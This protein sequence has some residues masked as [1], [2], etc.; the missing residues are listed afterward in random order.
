MEQKATD[1]LKKISL[2]D[3]ESLL[4][5]K[6]PKVFDKILLL[7]NSLIRDNF[8]Q[9]N[10]RARNATRSLHKL[11]VPLHS[12]I[13]SLIKNLLS[14]RD[15]KI[16]I[17]IDSLNKI[18]SI[19]GCEKTNLYRNE[20]KNAY[21]F[22]LEE[23]AGSI[24]DNQ[25]PYYLPNDSHIDDCHTCNGEKYIACNN[26]D[27][28][29]RHEWT[30]PNC[31]GDGKV[32]CA[33]CSGH[34][35]I[36]CNDC[37]G[38]GEK[39]C[40]NLIWG[41]NGS[42]KV[43]DDKTRKNKTCTKCKG[44][45][46]IKCKTCK[47]KGE[48]AC[49]RCSSKGVVVCSKCSGKKTI[50]CKVCYGDQKRY[51]LVDCPTCLTNG[52]LISFYYVTTD[53]NVLEDKNL[54]RYETGVLIKDSKFKEILYD[55]LPLKTFFAQNNKGKQ[56]T[57]DKYSRAFCK[58]MRK[59]FDLEENKFP[60]LISE[61]LSYQI[62]ACIDFQ[63]KHILTNSTH[64]ASILD[65]WSNPNIVFNSNPEQEETRITFSN[66]LKTISHFVGKLF[67]TEKYFVRRDRF[68]EITL[69]IYMIRADGSIDNRE[70][71]NLLE[72]ISSLTEFT[73]SEKSKLFE[74]LDKETLPEIDFSKMEFLTESRRKEC[75]DKL[76]SLAKSDDNQSQ[77]EIEFLK[78][79]SGISL[80]KNESKIL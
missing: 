38:K 53:I 11:E 29:G 20:V 39:K 9:V 66:I 56:E 79:V 59:R 36:E 55:E 18:L 14:K 48:I 69:L 49:S 72:E 62:I 42:G 58:L 24:L 21:N 19:R 43:F 78:L 31:K 76:L 23:D 5:L 50:T 68:N 26:S 63:Y 2:E 60:K 51:G 27:C 77:S 28:K 41:C 4:K 40:G 44:K 74:L 35:K 15:D 22:M 80:K 6:Q 67:K 16:I 47:T 30:C 34:G 71:V 57:H 70:K 61:S 3:I 46:K 10:Y 64:E 32:T 17:D 37:K 73:N 75:S 65:F 25:Q 12:S 8:I 45:G 52:K 7:E 54:I 33:I 1:Q 13:A